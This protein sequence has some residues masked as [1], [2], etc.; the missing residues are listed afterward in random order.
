MLMTGYTNCRADLRVIRHT[1]SGVSE[2]FE[3]D[4]IALAGEDDP[5]EKSTIGV[6]AI[7]VNARANIPVACSSTRS[8]RLRG[9]EFVLAVLTNVDRVTPPP[10]FRPQNV[11]VHTRKLKGAYADFR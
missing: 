6:W 9:R 3:V 8:V 11:G 1:R 10:R 4:I 2:G 5:A 7:H